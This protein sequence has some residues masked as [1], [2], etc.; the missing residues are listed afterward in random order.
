MLSLI[1]LKLTTAESAGGPTIWD[2]LK[3]PLGAV[4]VS[5]NHRGCNI[6][7][8]TCCDS[9]L[10]VLIL[11]SQ[12]GISTQACFLPHHVSAAIPEFIFSF[13]SCSIMCYCTPS[14]IKFATESFVILL[15]CCI[16]PA[17]SLIQ[18]K[19][20]VPNGD[21]V[22]VVFWMSLCGKS[23]LIKLL[24]SEKFRMLQYIMSGVWS[25]RKFCL[26]RKGG[27]GCRSLGFCRILV[28]PPGHG[29]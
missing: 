15:L 13:P 7:V 6:C 8:R 4:A 29:S 10:M 16:C 14:K 12:V 19:L 28:L 26:T 22:V 17:K 18:Q 5:I 3:E 25:V 23:C 27:C 21:G 24:K 2:V 11:V 20:P 9:S 1:F